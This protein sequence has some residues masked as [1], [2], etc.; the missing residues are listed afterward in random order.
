MV[1][2]EEEYEVD[3]DV[4]SFDGNGME[5]LIHTKKKETMTL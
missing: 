2:E 1:E 5:V 3:D 4:H